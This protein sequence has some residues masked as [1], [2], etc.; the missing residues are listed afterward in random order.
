MAGSPW[1]SA[2]GWQLGDRCESVKAIDPTTPFAHRRRVAAVWHREDSLSWRELQGVLRTVCSNGRGPFA[3][4]Q[5]S[6]RCQHSFCSNQQTA[7]FVA[8]KVCSSIEQFTPSAP[9]G[10]FAG[11][12]GETLTC[13]NDVV[14]T[15]RVCEDSEWC[16]H[17]VFM[18]K[19]KFRQGERLC[20]SLSP[21]ALP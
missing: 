21:H 11:R 18:T 6:A 3:A 15:V 16:K 13:R 10:C 12:T 4:E 1:A 19:N 14:C 9:V 2:Y 5:T 20:S 7:E 17:N 8:G